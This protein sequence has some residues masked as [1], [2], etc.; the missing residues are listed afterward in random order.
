MPC[1]CPQAE[2]STLTNLQALDL[3]SSLINGSIPQTASALTALTYL[4]VGNTSISGTLP[5]VGMCSRWWRAAVSTLET[6][7][8]QVS[9]APLISPLTS[10]RDCYKYL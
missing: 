7:A 8:K 2:L 3:S 5:Q 6:D 4:D 9:S 1:T 10:D